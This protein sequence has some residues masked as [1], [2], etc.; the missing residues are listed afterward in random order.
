MI[1]NIKV[2]IIYY[3]SNS[4][5]EMEFTLCGC[6][7]MRLLTDKAADRRSF[8]HSLARAVSRSRV[9]IAC[10][11]LFGED[12]L[13][14]SVAQAI[15]RPLAAADNKAYGI[16]DENEIEIIKGSMPL[17]T[18]EG[19]FGGCIIESGPQ[20][21]ILLTEN[22]SIRKPIMSSLIHPYIEELSLLQASSA[23]EDEQAAR[24]ESA[25]AG[26]TAETEEPAAPAE[27][28]KDAETPAA[29]DPAAAGEIPAA[30]AVPQAGSSESAEPAAPE[31]DVKDSEPAPENAA[32]D[33]VQSA[34]EPEAA[35]PAEAVAAEEPAEKSPVSAPVHDIPFVFSETAPAKKPASSEADSPELYI[36]P[37]RPKYSRKS[38]YDTDAPVSEGDKLLYTAAD[39][40]PAHAPRKAHSFRV[41][42][43]VLSILL[44]L[45]LA[46]LAYL[47]IY[48]PMR[49]G[50]TFT[51]YVQKIFNTSATAARMGFRPF[52]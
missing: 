18:G 33:P 32:S 34:P 27:E 3:R 39:E 49:D 47:L 52:F 23:L 15:G 21:I 44:L 31:G 40:L 42:L 45:A 46:A 43:L 13:I 29:T 4:D 48:V 10:G 11:G 26:E 41:P 20:T 28:A 9:I 37:Q 16:D 17:V 51:E 7:H 12:G 5:F 19:Y 30:E 6:C 14:N 8:V 35:A 24:E 36:E 50:Y 38:Y 22:K 25:P 2:D 1:Q